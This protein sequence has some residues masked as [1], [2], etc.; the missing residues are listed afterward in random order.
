MC[1]VFMVEGMYVVVN[2]MLCL[3]YVM[4][5]PALCSIW[6]RTVVKLCKLGVFALC[7]SLV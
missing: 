3:M 7:V 6:A 4:I 2:V 5:P 1:R